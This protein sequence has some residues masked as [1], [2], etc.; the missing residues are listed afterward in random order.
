VRPWI[1]QAVRDDRCSSGFAREIEQ[2]IDEHSWRQCESAITELARLHD[3]IEALKVK[4]EELEE[5]LGS[6]RRCYAMMLEV[7][8]KL[9]D[10]IDEANKKITELEVGSERAMSV[11]RGDG[12]GC[13]GA[14]GSRG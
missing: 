8:G 9:T 10:E 7:N 6:Y 14:E 2:W 3:Q 1:S 13:M 12:R 5:G 4:A 11:V